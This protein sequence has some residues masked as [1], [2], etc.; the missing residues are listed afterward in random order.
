MAKR[1]PEFWQ[2]IGEL[3]FVAAFIGAV[4]QSCTWG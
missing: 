2:R 1:P 3:L 4:V